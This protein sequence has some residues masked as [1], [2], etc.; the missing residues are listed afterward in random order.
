VKRD[1][2]FVQ[3]NDGLVRIGSLFIGFQDVFQRRRILIVEF[4]GSGAK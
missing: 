3:A 1:G 2:L 4:R